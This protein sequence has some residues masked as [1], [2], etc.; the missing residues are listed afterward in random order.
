VLLST[1]GRS[2][3]SKREMIDFQIPSSWCPVSISS[4][5]PAAP[6]DD[7]TP[8]S[9]PMRLRKVETTLESGVCED[10]LY[11]DRVQERRPSRLD[12]FRYP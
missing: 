11:E 9:Y 1:S 7:T 12:L 8:E 3:V 5:T 10:L 4:R 6:A 2:G